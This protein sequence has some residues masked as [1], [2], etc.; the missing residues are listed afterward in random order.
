MSNAQ[1]DRQYVDR[2]TLGRPLDTTFIGG[3][4]A[5]KPSQKPSPK[6][7]SFAYLS[8]EHFTID[9]LAGKL[10][11]ISNKVVKL[12]DQQMETKLRVLM[13]SPNEVMLATP[14]ETVVYKLSNGT[15]LQEI[16]RRAYP[17][18]LAG[19]GR[20]ESLGAIICKDYT[21][22]FVG[23]LKIQDACKN[24]AIKTPKQVWKDDEKKLMR[25]WES[26]FNDADEESF[27]ER[28]NLGRTPSPQKSFIKTS[29]SQMSNQEPPIGKHFKVELASPEKSLVRA[30]QYSNFS[31]IEKP[32]W[33][34]VVNLTNYTDTGRS[35][36]AGKRTQTSASTTGRQT[37]PFQSSIPKPPTKNRFPN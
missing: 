26:R 16:E 17:H 19:I 22:H 30:S 7:E 4:S 13:V 2:T 3:R 36:E 35:K 10:G 27:F 15:T 14:S 34:K 6:D 33:S 21:C 18:K 12:A 23:Y 28:G 5:E 29:Y 31:K 11:Y 37:S 8:V 25:E 24:S 20:G 1:Q 32:N 9:F